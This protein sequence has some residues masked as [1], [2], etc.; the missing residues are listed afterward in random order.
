MPPVAGDIVQDTE[1]GRNLSVAD[2]KDLIIGELVQSH[3]G[4]QLM[5]IEGLAGEFYIFV[6][7]RVVLITSLADPFREPESS[8]PV[9]GE[10]CKEFVTPS[11]ED[12]SE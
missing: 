1:D 8:T 4:L 6:T 7:S 3:E 10:G 11:E 2:F 5:S 9:A 12:A